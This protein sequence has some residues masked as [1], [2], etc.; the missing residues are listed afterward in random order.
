[1]VFTTE[2]TGVNTGR[3]LSKNILLKVGRFNYFKY[4]VSSVPTSLPAEAL[5]KEG[6]LW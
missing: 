3:T 4:S 1:M 5:A 6:P 2:N